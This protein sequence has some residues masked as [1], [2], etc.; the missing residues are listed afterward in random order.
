MNR[1][2]D[3]FYATSLRYVSGHCSTV[4]LARTGIATNPNLPPRIRNR[5]SSLK[6]FIAS[7]P[8]LVRAPN[9]RRYSRGRQII[10]L[11]VDDQCDRLYIA[12][13]EQLLSH[14]RKNKETTNV[15]QNKS[16]DGADEEYDVGGEDV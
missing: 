14:L 15:L 12:G 7:A 9:D 8:H 16:K 1:Y 10:R 11:K 13:Q 6:W 3:P 4:S 2:A 5:R